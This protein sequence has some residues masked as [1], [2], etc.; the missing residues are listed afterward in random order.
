MG[1]WEATLVCMPLS[2]ARS[3]YGT[4]AECAPCCFPHVSRPSCG[5]SRQPYTSSSS[6]NASR[7]NNGKLWPHKLR[8]EKHDSAA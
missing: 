4:K 8:G 7:A 3:D 5:A 1:S 6:I 2:T